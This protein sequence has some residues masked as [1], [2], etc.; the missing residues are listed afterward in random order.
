LFHQP[1]SRSR[2]SSRSGRLSA[3]HCE[4]HSRSTGERKSHTVNE[5]RTG[6]G[7]ITGDGGL[8]NGGRRAKEKEGRGGIFTV[9]EVEK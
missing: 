8:Y 6:T 3:A 5:R 1:G 7:Q 9:G 2:G 4:V